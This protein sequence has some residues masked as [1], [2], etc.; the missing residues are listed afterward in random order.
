MNLIIKSGIVAGSF[1]WHT[2]LYVGAEPREG[3]V[4]VD[5]LMHFRA[6]LYEPHIAF[7]DS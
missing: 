5:D 1:F 2:R 4:A 7:R 3:S 6:R